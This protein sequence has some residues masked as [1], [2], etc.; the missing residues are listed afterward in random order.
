M[1]GGTSSGSLE[2]VLVGPLVFSE[3]KDNLRATTTL[4]ISSD[5]A[6]LEAYCDGKEQEFPSLMP[7]QERWQGEMMV[8]DEGKIQIKALPAE[9]GLSMS[10]EFVRYLVFFKG[11]AIL[12]V[13]LS[14]KSQE[15]IRSV[16]RDNGLPDVLSM[17]AEDAASAGVS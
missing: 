11:W 14:T 12:A 6:S 16:L 7:T 13:C 9:V 15:E 17:Q 10:S 3:I 4:V 5:P 8:L 1:V 2:I